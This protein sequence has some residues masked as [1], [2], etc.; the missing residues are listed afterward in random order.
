MFLAVVNV[1]ELRGLCVTG[2]YGWIDISVLQHLL[3]N[4]DLDTAT[5]PQCCVF[6]AYPSIVLPISGIHNDPLQL[7][8]EHYHF[9]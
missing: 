1:D 2:C 5:T 6:N 3:R 4:S 7:A 9:P 8:E